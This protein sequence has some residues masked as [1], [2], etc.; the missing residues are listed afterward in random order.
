MHTLLQSLHTS[1]I[2]CPIVVLHYK[3]MKN[4]KSVASRTH[5]RD[6]GAEIAGLS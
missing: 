2:P 1:D 3:E 5:R 4:S 6:A